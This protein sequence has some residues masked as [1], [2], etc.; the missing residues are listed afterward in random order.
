MTVAEAAMGRSALAEVRHSPRFLVLMLVMMVAAVAYGGRDTA[1][2]RYMTEFTGDASGVGI[3]GAL[4]AVGLAVGG[5]LS[6]PISDRFDPRRLLVA[7][8]AL[9]GIGSLIIAGMLL[10]GVTNPVAYEAMTFVDGAFAGAC[11]P[12][13]LTTQA[14][15]VPTNARGSAEIISI[16]RLGIGA[17]FGILLAGLSPS[18]V[19]TV[20]SVG[21]VLVA[22]AVP[23]ALITAPV[24]IPRR[25]RSLAGRV[26]ATL[27]D[28][29]VLRRV[30]TADLVLC[31]VLPTQFT[32][33][34]LA[35]RGD[36]SFVSAALV[37]GV[38]GVLVGRLI[39]TATGSHGPVRRQLLVSDGGFI[40][41]CFIGIAMVATDAAFAS[42][43]VP[44]VLLFIGAG[45]S[46]YTQGLLAALVQQQ[47]PDDVRGRLS[48]AMAA[49]RSL[50]IAGSAA[51]LTAIVV[52][53]SAIGGVTFVA[54]SG[55]VAL[56]ILR[57]FR[58]IT[59]SAVR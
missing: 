3:A 44:A 41:L 31:I 5:L 28:H 35:D 57:G 36:E 8:M 56:L 10:L 32:N 25:A 30:V 15:M 37:G 52:P 6:G 58:G 40:G 2:L 50:L 27:R 29:P 1:R 48:G 53:L 47:V 16:L 7:G 18:P 59:A 21:V 38:L 12:A 49:A 33:L 34:I 23:I 19:V 13:L 51:L 17:V 45:L 22:V 9:Q 43:W 20:I 4:F 11:V 42:P 24:D 26:L 54:V 55:L 39:L 46:A 14:A